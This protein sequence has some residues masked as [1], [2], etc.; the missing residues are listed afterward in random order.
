M[1]FR[2]K[3][4]VMDPA[5]EN[6]DKA[7]DSEGDTLHI[8]DGI[9]KS[10][11]K[12]A[13]HP[14]LG[15][16][17]DKTIQETLEKCDNLTSDAVKKMLLKLVK[18]EHVLAFALLK[19]EEQQK[20]QQGKTSE[21]DEDDKKSETDAPA[22]PKLTRLKA[23]QLNQKLP[24]PGP[25]KTPELCE[26]VVT[27]IQEPLVNSDDED[28]NEY[29]PGDE[30]ASDEDITNTT[31]SDVESQ[32]STPGSALFYNEQDF[33]SPGKDSEFKMPRTRTL[34]AVSC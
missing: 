25:L 30:I 34:S 21:S 13:E 19:A 28:E 7:S 24:V 3:L 23:K 22:T 15:D 17:L 31:F 18:N 5:E 11:K 14:E 20:V 29:Q 8:V 12:R 16:A 2:I 9:T 26:D 1:K 10:P 6:R 4:I 33:E 27:L 32:P